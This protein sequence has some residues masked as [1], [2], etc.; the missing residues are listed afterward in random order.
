ML[1]LILASASPTR[2]KL[3]EAIDLVPE[4]IITTDI[5]ETP[6]KGELPRNLAIRLSKQKM[7]K[8]LTMVEKGYI[9]T[10]DTVSAVGRR[11][12]PKAETDEDV[13]YCLNMISGRRHRLYTGMNI[14]KKEVGQATIIRSKISQTIIKFNR[15]SDRDLNWYLDSK[16][17][18]GKAGG[19]AILGKAQIFINFIRGAGVSNVAGL[20]LP[21]VNNMLTSLG[22][23]NRS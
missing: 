15:L 20:P 10:A 12:L 17:G 9:I 19:Y 7:Q 8:A 6:L 11:I 22:Y 1:P 16:E 5:D 3:L 21:E 14:A 2:K 23:Y 18:I 4:K 13:R